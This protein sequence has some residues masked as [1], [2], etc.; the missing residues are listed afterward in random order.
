MTFQFGGLSSI[1]PLPR[2]PLRSSSLFSSMSPLLFDWR[3]AEPQATDPAPTMPA[4]NDGVVGS[5]DGA[6]S[7]PS[8]LP[9]MAEGSRRH[10]RAPS[11]LDLAIVAAADD[12]PPMI[13][14]DDDPRGGTTTKPR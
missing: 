6:F 11:D 3:L 5:G 10:P 1:A 7:S 2:L 8:S 14:V 4:L 9:T 13:L 12:V